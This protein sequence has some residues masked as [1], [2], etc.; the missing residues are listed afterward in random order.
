MLRLQILTNM[1]MEMDRIKAAAL[2]QQPVGLRPLT[3]GEVT[4]LLSQQPA[5]LR[6]LFPEGRILL[7]WHPYRTMA[8]NA[9]LI[10]RSNNRVFVVSSAEDEFA[11]AQEESTSPESLLS[12]GSHYRCQ[13][14]RNYDIDI[15][16]T[17]SDA[18]LRAHVVWHLF[19]LA[20][21]SADEKMAVV[22]IF[23]ARKLDS[24]VADLQEQFAVRQIDLPFEK[25]FV[26]ERDFN[27]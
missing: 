14:G 22:K 26:L 27:N 10:F 13:R 24:L 17:G 7:D 9:D 19:R 1:E 23:Y 15:F 4:S 20:E 8:A 3:F 11:S 6:H 2:A 18:D 25:V 5:Q 16:G 12:C 21:V